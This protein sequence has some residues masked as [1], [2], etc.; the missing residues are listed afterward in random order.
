V[1]L[2]SAAAHAAL[3]PNPTATTGNHCIDCKARHVCKT[4][5][6]ST[7]N[8]IDYSATAELQPLDPVSMGQELRILRMAMK[9][10]EARETGLAAQVEATLRAGE[11]VPFFSMQ[12]KQTNR[13]WLEN[14]SIE[15]V[16][17]LGELLGIE[18]VKPPALITPTQAIDAGIDERIVMQYAHRPPGAL[19]LK[20]DDAKATRKAFS[21]R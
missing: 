6:H 17:A 10:L 7:A 18:L 1:N 15:E 9:R 3:A 19:A 5:R 12:P 4:L 8:I 20:Q 11:S 2:A 13:Q 14:A 16:R 21:K